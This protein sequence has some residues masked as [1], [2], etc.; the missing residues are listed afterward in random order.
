MPVPEP[1]VTI[2]PDMLGGTP[3]FTGT[4][5][6]IYLMFN[7]LEGGDSIGAFVEA[8]P[9]VSLDHAVAVLRQARHLVAPQN[10]EVPEP[11]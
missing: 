4:R 10:S 6:P 11:A 5:V 9:T 3:V 7:Y 8:H 2:H 1:L